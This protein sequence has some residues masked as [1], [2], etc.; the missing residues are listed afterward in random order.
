MNSHVI[1]AIIA[2]VLTLGMLVT[3]TPPALLLPIHPISYRI[4]KWYWTTS[5]S[6]I[7]PDSNQSMMSPVVA[8]LFGNS[9]PYVIFS[10]FVENVSLGNLLRVVNGITGLE[11]EAFSRN[12]QNNPV[13]PYASIAVA[14]IYNNGSNDILAVAQDCENIMCFSSTGNLR[15]KSNIVNADSIN[16]GGPAVAY[17][18]DTNFP[19]IIV[20][21]TVLHNNGA[22]DWKGYYGMGFEHYNDRSWLHGGVGPFSAVANL[23]GSGPDVVAGNTTYDAKGNVLWRANI[24]DGFPGVADFNKDG[25][26]EVVV[27]VSGTNNTNP[28]KVY[29]LNGQTGKLSTLWNHNPVILNDTGG[30][31]PTIA[32][33]TGSGYPEVG[34]ATSHNY[35]MINNN[36][37]IRWR[38]TINDSSSGVTCASAFD[39]TPHALPA[40]QPPEEYVQRAD[41]VY[42]D[43]TNLWVFDGDTGAVV[44]STNRPSGTTCEMPAIAD[45]DNDGHAEIVVC[46]NDYYTKTPPYAGILAYGDKAWQGC[47]SIWNQ[48]TY[49][50]TNIGDDA[51]VPTVE[52]DN[53]LIPAWTTHYNNYRCQELVVHSSPVA[54][55]SNIGL[56]AGPVRFDAST[57]QPGWNDTEILP[58]T[59][60]IWNFGDGNVTT[61]TTPVVYHTY[62]QSGKYSVT[63]TVDAPGATPETN[64]TTRMITIVSKSVGGISVP[65]ENL[66]LTT[67]YVGLVST[68]AVAA[69]ATA[70]CVKRVK[71]GKEKQ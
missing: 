43:Q 16:W 9:T 68:L 14:D 6:S 17:L 67:P 39:F 19:E 10:T 45:I 38:D 41:V 20:G 53:W 26:P 12:S 54:N 66:G 21:R 30:G 8:E 71:R 32:D 59:E 51:K 35:T 65:S 33:F 70:V 47:R 55:F 5:S 48:Y 37:T 31:A 28:C 61:I 1:T 15:W 4:P 52:F 62:T 64:S 50:I 44:W 46:A 13:D 49:H 29:L 11:D 57:S 22:L 63:L 36:G 3:I 2:V 27:V 18:N 42:A 24:T 56:P 7:E 60:Y 23:N 58:I 34:V 25:K 69:V 40:T